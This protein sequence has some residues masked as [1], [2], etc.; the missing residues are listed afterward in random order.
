ML[1]GLGNQ[2]DKTKAGYSLADSLHEGRA[3]GEDLWDGAI[4]WQRDAS[5]GAMTSR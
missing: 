4:Q 3:W 5:A 1:L 2:Q